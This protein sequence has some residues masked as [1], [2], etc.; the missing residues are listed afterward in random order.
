M[1]KAVDEPEM[2]LSPVLASTVLNPVQNVEFDRFTKDLGI[3]FGAS[4]QYAQ[5][6]QTI[7]ANNTTNHT[8]DSHNTYINGVQIGE[9]LMEKPLSEVL[10][11]LGLYQNM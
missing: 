3:L 4:G 8:T 10:S 2:V 9:S 5:S 11:L 1:L 7:P 6:T